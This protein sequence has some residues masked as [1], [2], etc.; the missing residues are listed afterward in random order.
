MVFVFLS[1]VCSMN[2]Y[3]R[4]RIMY[5]LTVPKVLKRGDTIALISISGG[6]AGDAE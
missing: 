3:W 5:K 2:L 4:R 1:I 6:K